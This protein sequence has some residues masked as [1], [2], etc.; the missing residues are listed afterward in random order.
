M[1]SDLDADARRALCARI[2]AARRS[3]CDRLFDDLHATLIDDCAA[4]HPKW[5]CATIRVDDHERCE[6]TKDAAACAAVDRQ[7]E[8]C[9][10]SETLRAR[11]PLHVG[12]VAPEG[13]AARAGLAAGDRVLTID[14]AAY[15]H[16]DLARA[17]AEISG[18][19][20][21]SVRLGVVS[22]SAAPRDLEVM[23]DVRE[24]RARIGVEFTVPP[25]CGA[26]LRVRGPL[27]CSM[28]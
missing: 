25:E 28:R 11:C 14:G 6:I 27:P 23:P 18:A 16:L 17:I 15:G 1:L 2:I 26:F 8:A 9:G 4:D 3:V 5:S 10:L 20:G 24:G 7:A 21:R 13:P 22:G 12:A 19:T